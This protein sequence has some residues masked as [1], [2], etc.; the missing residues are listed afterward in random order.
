M[1][2]LAL[3]LLLLLLLLTVAGCQKDSVMPDSE[4]V[5]PK[6]LG[7]DAAPVVETPAGQPARVTLYAMSE[8]PYGVPAEKVLF[9]V[10]QSLGEKMTARLAFIVEREE[11]GGLTSLHGPTEVEKDM[12]QAC[13]GRVAPDKQLTFVVEM[14][15]RA[16]QPW[17]E[18]AAGLQVDAAAVDA[19]LQDGTGID[20]LL[21]DMEET[22]SLQINSSPTIMLNDRKYTGGR[23]SRDLFDAV[24]AT[25]SK[26]DRPA[27]C[28]AP[29][30]FLSRTDPT[31]SGSCATDKAAA[32]EEPL[33]EEY[34]A[35][36]PFNHPVIYDPQAL[37]AARVEEVIDQTKKVYPMVNVQRIKYD[38]DEGRKM[39]SR[40]E[41]KTLPAFLFP[42]KIET[43]GN[44]EQMKNYLV[45]VKDM[46]VLDPKFGSSIFLDRQP[47]RKQIDIYYMPYSDK[48]VRVL[49]D[50]NDLAGRPD[51]QAMNVTIKLHPYALIEEGGMYSR[52]GA[53]E[54][55]EMLRQMAIIQT[56]A[57]KIWP[58][59]V[60]RYDRLSSSWWEDFIVKVGLDPQKIKQLAQSEEMEKQLLAVSTEA[61]QISAGEEIIFLF[62]NREKSRIEGKDQFKEALFTI[63]N[64]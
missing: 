14:N 19:C 47:I 28:D 26:A 18:I 16:K 17:T 23:D 31:G 20:L 4:S 8:C 49:L 22:V 43:F 24:C 51:V 63:G 46:Y 54:I 52:I 25:F 61:A 37:D 55:E 38:A 44:F 45:K 33:P 15:Q 9:D 10:K 53:T 21:K 59:L 30:D 57:A 13:V 60:G 29:P 3:P 32:E 56:D 35:R 5:K 64:R 34:V 6:P 50:I 12:I 40:Y 2:R 11:G 41:I 27:V 39:I 42:E 7:D 36:E 58:Y 48:A 1:K 62:E